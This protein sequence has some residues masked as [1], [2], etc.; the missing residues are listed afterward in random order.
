MAAPFDTLLLD[1]STW[2][3]VIDA[4]G[5]I[6]VCSA[7]YALSQDVASAAR[8]WAGEVWFDTTVGV[9]Y[10]QIL[11]QRPPASLVQTE[12]VK[13][14]LTVPGVVQATCIL[15]GFV[16]TVAA[17]NSQ[18]YLIGSPQVSGAWS[19]GSDVPAGSGTYSAGGGSPGSTIGDDVITDS[20]GEGIWSSGAAQ[21]AAPQVSTQRRLT[22]QILFV[23]V[24]GQQQGVAL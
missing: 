4:S 20:S 13:A 22:G 23:D 2:D 24:N 19:A 17:K 15:T 10:E 18:D 16:N 8:T 1:Q 21:A 12:M 11:G 5:N 3:L 6:A 7:P 9:P 14:A